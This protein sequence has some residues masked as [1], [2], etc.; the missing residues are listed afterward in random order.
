M[1]GHSWSSVRKT[2]IAEIP[3]TKTKS[4]T[5]VMAM[6]GPP[7]DLTLVVAHCFEDD[8]LLG[9][10]PEFVAAF[11]PKRIYVC[12]HCGRPIS[13]PFLDSLGVPIV[14]QE[15]L[16]PN[17]G[18]E[19]HCYMNYL[20]TRYNDLTAHQIFFQAFPWD[21]I[22]AVYQNRPQN[23]VGSFNPAHHQKM[24]GNTMLDLSKC[25]RKELGFV[26]LGWDLGIR[27]HNGGKWNVEH[28]WFQ[29]VDETDPMIKAMTKHVNRP[30]PNRLS[31]RGGSQFWVSREA[32]QANPVAVYQDIKAELEKGGNQGYTMEFLYPFLFH[33]PAD[34]AVHGGPDPGLGNEGNVAD[35]WRFKPGCWYAPT[36][37]IVQQVQCPQLEPVTIAGHVYN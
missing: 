12:E 1:V 26:Q 24:F 11:R 35:C 3:E 5:Q 36:Q 25:L 22:A 14:E 30:Y 27:N 34:Y 10:M 23:V 17:V 21:G 31:T 6:S 15:P 33:A 32:I 16:V 13:R 20:V 7:A 19:S 4:K 18:T 29:G 37:Q 8:S 28:G 9:W 2:M